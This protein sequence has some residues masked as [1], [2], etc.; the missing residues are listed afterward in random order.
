[1]YIAGAALDR[2]GLRTGRP[3]DRSFNPGRIKIFFF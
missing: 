3:T 2:A 1:M